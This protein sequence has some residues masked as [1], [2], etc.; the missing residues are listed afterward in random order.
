MQLK[1]KS[2]TAQTVRKVEP[3]IWLLPSILMMGVMILIPIITVFQ[4]SFSEISKAGVNRGW[5]G[6]ENYIAVFNNPT[7][8]NTLKNTLI[9]TVVVVGLSTVIGFTLAMILNVQFKGRKFA[10]AVIVFPWATALI[11]HSCT[12]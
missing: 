3:Y 12:A 7:F 2:N 6:I 4:S 8:W 11:I 5:N 1:G 10:R 9:W